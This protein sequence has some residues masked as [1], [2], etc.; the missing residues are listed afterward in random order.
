M[1]TASGKTVLIATDSQSTVS[2]LS[3]GPRRQKERM[4]QS[5]WEHLNAIADA[6]VN[7][8]LQFIYGHCGVH[9]NEMVDNAIVMQKQSILH[10][11]RNERR[12]SE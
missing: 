2:A 6:G 11:Q 10:L 1:S 5:T 4:T 12:K 9:L 8:H 3:L 7:V